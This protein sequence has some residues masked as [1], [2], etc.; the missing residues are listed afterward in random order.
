M[1]LTRRRNNFISLHYAYR[2]NQQGKLAALTVAVLNIS[3][4]KI[5][6]DYV[7]ST[8]KQVSTLAFLEGYLHLT[9]LD[10]DIVAFL[11]NP[12]SCSS[13]RG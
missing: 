2:L 12:V 3:F 6:K 11:S 4:A 7:V 5:S 9:Q 13:F 1:A 10:L 8:K